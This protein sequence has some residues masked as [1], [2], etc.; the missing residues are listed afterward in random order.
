MPGHSQH[1]HEPH[2]PLA[3]SQSADSENA[4]SVVK[5]KTTTT[6][7]TISSTNFTYSVGDI[8]GYREL[9]NVLAKTQNSGGDTPE[10]EQNDTEQGK[11]LGKSA[12]S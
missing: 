8:V 2:E 3:D 11:A 9:G 5:L 1:V 4:T 7:T 12:T 10:R 6:R